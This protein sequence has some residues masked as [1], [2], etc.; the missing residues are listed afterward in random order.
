[1]SQKQADSREQNRSPSPYVFPLLL[2]QIIEDKKNNAIVTI[3][4]MNNSYLVFL[5][6]VSGGEKIG[7]PSKPRINTSL[8]IPSP[9]ASE[10][11]GKKQQTCYTFFQLHVRFFF[12][13]IRKKKW[14]KNRGHRGNFTAVYLLRQNHGNG[15]P[16]NNRGNSQLPEPYKH[17]RNTQKLYCTVPYNYR[18]I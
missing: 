9:P 4:K 3:E 13:V 18:E 7:F 2:F 14:K 17:R 15:S 10:K 1:M 5:L 16:L 8:L 12:F 6:F 11:N